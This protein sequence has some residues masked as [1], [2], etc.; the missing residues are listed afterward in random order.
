MSRT[1][2][3]KKNPR[4]RQ[5][6]PK[7]WLSYEKVAQYLLGQFASH[8]GLGRV[9]GKQIV[10]GKRSG[11]K[12]EIEAKGVKG[13]G[14]GFLIIECRRYTK[15]RLNQE[16]LGGLEIRPLDTEEDGGIVVI[17]L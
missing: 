1:R 11:S 8:F 4:R 10:P 17:A 13:G 16:S 3:R 7:P 5:P 6:K 15:S 9:E 2:L 14:E 12:W